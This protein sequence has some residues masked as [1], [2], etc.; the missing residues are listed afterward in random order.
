[1]VERGARNELSKKPEEVKKVE[2]ERREKQRDYQEKIDADA[3][4]EDKAGGQETSIVVQ[5]L[6]YVR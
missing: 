2:E 5:D 1:M 6:K 4:N 3:K